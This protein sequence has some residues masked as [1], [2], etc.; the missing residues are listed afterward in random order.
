M[1]R[2]VSK[3]LNFQ[4]STGRSPSSLHTMT[5]VYVVKQLLP[6]FLM[7]ELI[8]FKNKYLMNRGALQ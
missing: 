4:R 5:P 1:L 3:A 6:S 8:I 7:V 2:L